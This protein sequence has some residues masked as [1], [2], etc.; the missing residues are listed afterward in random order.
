MFREVKR[1]FDP[2]NVLNPGKV[3]GDDPDLMTRNLRPTVVASPPPPPE[4]QPLEA[5]PTHLVELELNWTCS[6]VDG[7]GH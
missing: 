4:E 3:I 6:R 2:Q 5:A 7:S 1:I